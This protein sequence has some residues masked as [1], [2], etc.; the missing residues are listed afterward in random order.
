[1]RV[2]SNTSVSVDRY[3][4]QGLGVDSDTAVSVS[5]LSGTAVTHTEYTVSKGIA[6]FR[7]LISTEKYLRSERGSVIVY[8]ECPECGSEDVTELGWSDEFK[9]ANMRCDDCGHEWK[10]LM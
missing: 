4:P 2:E 9:N 7:A 5:E 1:M 6:L 10:S 3:F 8:S